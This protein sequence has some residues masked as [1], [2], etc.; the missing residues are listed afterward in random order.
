MSTPVARYEFGEQWVRCTACW[1]M[2]FKPSR[3]RR[4]WWATRHRCASNT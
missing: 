1:L 4:L 2:S 3:L